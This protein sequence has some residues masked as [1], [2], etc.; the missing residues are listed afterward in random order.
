MMPP[1]GT[2]T[3]CVMA[4]SGC[5]TTNTMG[6]APCFD[7]TIEEVPDANS[8]TE[9]L[10]P[11]EFVG[12]TWQGMSITGPG[13]YTKTFNTPEGCPYDSIKEYDGF[14]APDVGQIDTVVCAEMYSYE[15][16]DYTTSGT[17][18][19]QYP[20]GSIYGCDSTAMLHLHLIY[21]ESSIDFYC[22]AQQFVLTSMINYAIP[23]FSG[24]QYQWYWNG[25]AWCQDPTCT[26]PYDGTF[27]LFVS[28]EINGVTCTYEAEGSPLTITLGD[29]VPPPP[30]VN[31]HSDVACALEYGE[32]SV[33]EDD[34]VEY[35]TWTAIPAG[36]PIFTNNNN[37]SELEV[38]WEGFNS[39]TIC[40][41]ATNAC[42]EGE[43]TCFDITVIPSPIAD[44]TMPSAACVDSAVTITFTGQ[45]SST[46]TFIWN[47]GSGATI[48]SGGT[49]PGPHIV[50]W[51]APGTQTV[52][53]ELTEMGCDTDIISFPIMIEALGQPVVSCT[54]TLNSVTFEWDDVPGAD[55]YTVNVLQ[56][57]QGMLLDDTSYVVSGLAPGTTVQIEVSAIGLGA[58]AEQTATAQCIAQ[59]CPPKMI[60]I[61]L[62]SDSFCLGDVSTPIQLSATVDGS[63]ATG[64]WSGPGVDPSGT[65]DPHD[66]AAGVGQSQIVFMY[67]EG[68]CDY[69]KSITVYVLDT[70]TATFTVDDTICQSSNASVQYTG[71]A[72]LSANFAWDF[73]TATV[74][75]GSG[76]GPYALHWNAPGM[77]TVSL[78]VD[79]NN[80]PSQPVSQTVDV[81]PEL[82]MPNLQ[83]FPTTSSVTIQWSNVPNATAYDVMSLFGPPG[84]VNGNQYQVTGLMPGDSVAIQLTI[85]GNTVCPPLVIET[86]C[87]AK[88]CP[89]PQIDLTPVDD[90]CLYP[91]TGNVDLV[92]TVTNGTGAGTW[93]GTGVT[94]P[95]QGV[96]D[97][98]MAGS[99][100]HTISY[101]YLDQGCSFVET[102]TINVYDP[103]VAVISNASLILTCE[104]GNQLDL[105][106]S[107]STAPG[108]VIYQWSTTNGV[109][110]GATDGPVATA[111]AK[112]D[113]TL[114]VTDAVSGCADMAT[115]SVAQDAGVPVADAGPDGLINCN[116]NSATLGGNSST[117]A[118][119]EYLWT[120][121]DGAIAS[122][123]TASTITASA[124]GTYNLLVTDNANGCTSVDQVM[125]AVDTLHPS[126]ALSVSDIL[127]CDTQTSTVSATVSPAGGNYTYQWVTSDGQIQ[128]G[129][130]SASVIVN[131]AG[132]YTVY[133][134]NQTNGCSDT[135]STQ[136]MSDP[137]VISALESSVDNPNCVGDVNGQIDITQ[138][139]G[140]T[141]PYTYAWS[142]QVSTAALSNLGPGTYSVTVTDAN[143]C[144]LTQ[145]YTLPAPVAITP[146]IGPDIRYNIDDTVTITLSVTDPGAIGDVIWEG[147]A[148]QCPGCFVNTFVAQ[149]TGDVLVTAVDTNGCEATTMLHLTVYRPRN[150]FAPN[151]FSPNGDG[152]NDNFIIRGNT[153]ETI[154][155][156]RVFDRWGDLVYEQ[157]NLDPNSSTGWDGTFKGKELTPGVYVYMAQLHHDDGLEQF[158]SGDVTLV[159]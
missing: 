135:S 36:I 16:T 109:I 114:L 90:I 147:V 113:Y 55:S 72:S 68:T 32:Y 127:D 126:T 137:A 121:A 54:S 58:C 132:T 8:P 130:T 119:I 52:T 48:I 60:A 131:R 111:G 41:T 152:I 155:V 63:P 101:S 158:I 69:Q 49:G 70:P 26:S 27:E 105:D 77:Y 51:G 64:T 25:D 20:N 142:N 116:I 1:P 33:V 150:I 45:A 86:S 98:V 44:F 40:V 108:G 143:G 7:L 124:G 23:G 120:T 128:S 18:L 102:I 97:P 50:S 74:M 2:Y 15:G 47:F 159:R 92:A 80:C 149:V 12:L 76:A 71:T 75:N 79:E 82:Q 46:S 118:S 93:S 29:L 112:G 31:P 85:S 5:D 78:M 146:D 4:F 153:L 154:L 87:V 59:S 10:C 19:L 42:G 65:F 83:C 28:Y 6:D 95:I 84:T 140:G 144:S 30:E 14:P 35:Y 134:T 122:D 151:V 100:S 22:D 73:G 94:D 62:P 17:Y 13:I 145:S 21:I 89:T 43:P 88:A 136:V 115:V 117:G 3:I 123:P 133:V 39:G 34:N 11:E 67:S 103:P 129:A 56:G 96:F 57:P 110:L 157:Y 148:P 138:V 37:N 125:V 81:Q 99:G 156:M 139:V 24:L 141:P 107:S 66:P 104:N 38:D 9:I 61:Q 106:G 91:G 53:L